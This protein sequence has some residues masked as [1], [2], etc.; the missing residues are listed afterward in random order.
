LLSEA[1]AARIARTIARDPSTTA[2]KWAQRSVTDGLLP[3]YSSKFRSARTVPRKVKRTIMQLRC[4]R[5]IANGLLNKWKL[6]PSARCPHCSSPYGSYDD[7]EHTLADCLHPVLKGKR[8][9]RH[10]EGANTIA[11]VIAKSH[12][13]RPWH[14]NISAGRRFRDSTAP[15]SD[16]IPTWALP[17]NV[18]K[19]DLV[20]ILGWSADMPIPARP[21]PDIEFIIGDVTYGRGHTNTA[22]IVKKQQKYQRL[23]TALRAR[24][25]TV[26]TVET[27]TCALP[28]SPRAAQPALQPQQYDSIPVFSFGATGEIYSSN[29]HAFRAFDIDHHH[30]KTLASSI[31]FKSI[32]WAA[33]ILRAR[34]AI[35]KD[36]HAHSTPIAPREGEG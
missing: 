16:T 18:L 36:P 14:L 10:D 28:P 25:W 35:D 4:G 26:R 17:D 2:A 24:G 12:R 20:L 29:L 1:R 22:R 32:K 34:R 31:H 23:V 6:A 30:C 11:D 5:W 8:T 15:L 7:G 27:G 13:E 9:F 33:D 3:E 21:T 19:P